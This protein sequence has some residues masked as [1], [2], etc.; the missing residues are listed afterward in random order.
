[1]WHYPDFGHKSWFFQF[2]YMH[3]EYLVDF[4][5]N[6]QFGKYPNSQAGCINNLRSPGNGLAHS[7]LAWYPNILNKMQQ[8][9]RPVRSNWP[10][11]C[12]ICRLWTT[13]AFPSFKRIHPP[14][15]MAVYVFVAIT[16][17]AP[18]IN[19]MSSSIPTNACYQS[20]MCYCCNSN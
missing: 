12:A 19:D 20:S 1:M 11:F 6:V 10:R 9:K 16:S 2:V 4:T 17:S 15:V 3:F 13:G 7:S 8:A 14:T 5:L 18:K